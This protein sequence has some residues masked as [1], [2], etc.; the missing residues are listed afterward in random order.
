MAMSFAVV[1]GARIL[2]P[3]VVSKSYPGFW[4]DWRR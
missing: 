1:P 4:E 2:H 3:D